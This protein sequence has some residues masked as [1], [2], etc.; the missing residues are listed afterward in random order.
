MG[1][2]QGKALVKL[3]AEFMHR[4]VC[5]DIGPTQTLGQYDRNQSTHL[6]SVQNI[7]ASTYPMSLH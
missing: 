4:D 2:Y 6:E 1:F 5:I 3:S 7:F